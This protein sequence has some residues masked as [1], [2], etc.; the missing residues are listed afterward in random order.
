MA[1]YRKSSNYYSTNDK[2]LKEEG[3]ETCR[4]PESRKCPKCSKSQ[5]EL[6]ETFPQ[7]TQEEGCEG[8]STPLPEKF[9]LFTTSTEQSGGHS[10]SPTFLQACRPFYRSNL[11]TG[12]SST[13]KQIGS[14]RAWEGCQP[15][16]TPWTG[17][18][19]KKRY[20]TSLRF[21]S[22]STHLTQT[23]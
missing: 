4:P 13:L 15:S 17:L 7:L 5:T 1:I 21:E 11:T 22:L 8:H 10:D 23:V 14:P 19:T 6:I 9:L 16:L 2:S 12:I 18:L 20:W 3:S